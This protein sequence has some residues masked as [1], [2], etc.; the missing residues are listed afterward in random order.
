MKIWL[1]SNW[2]LYSYNFFIQEYINFMEESWFGFYFLKN[3]HILIFYVYQIRKQKH[4]ILY[5]RKNNIYKKALMDFPFWGYSL[6]KILMTAYII[7]L[8]CRYWQQQMV[9]ITKLVAYS[10]REN[11]PIYYV[12]PGRKHSGRQ[13]D[14]NVLRIQ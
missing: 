5:C 7:F 2:K 8:L 4:A 6:Q 13:W 9:E 10:F 12:V 14:L 1:L 11:I 3:K